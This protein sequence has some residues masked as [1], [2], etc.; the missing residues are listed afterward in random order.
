MKFISYENYIVLYWDLPENFVK[1]NRYIIFEGNKQIA[2]TEQC[3]IKIGGL[4][5]DSTHLFTV[6]MVGVSSADLGEI[7]ART[8]RI[9][10]R[11]DVTS[12]PYFAVGDGKTLNTAALQQAFDDCGVNDVIYI[13]PG[14]FLTGSLRLHSDT[15]LYL[16]KGA[17][18]HGTTCVSDYEPKIKSRFEGSE[19][20]SYAALLN[21]GMLE[22]NSSDTCSNIR[23]FGEGTVCGGGLTLAQNVVS[24]ETVLMKEYISS[25]GE[26]A[27]ECENFDTIPGRVRPR[28][29]NI[30]SANNIVISGITVQNGACWNVHMI[31]SD[32]IV[33]YGCTFRSEKVWNGD[34]W[35]PDSSTNCTLFG[36]DFYTGDDAVAVKSGKNP[37]GNIVNKPCEHIKVF[38]CVSHF[39][40]G[41]TIG[42]EISGGINDVRI[43]N[44]DMRNSLF[45]IEIK[46]TKKRGGYVKNVDVSHSTVCRILMH[47]VGYNDDG[48][49]APTPPAFENCRFSDMTVT[50]TMFGTDETEKHCEAIE[51]S[52]F[53]QE[54][55]F[56]KNILFKNIIIDS[57]EKSRKQSIF[58]KCC[59]GVTLQNV[60]T[61]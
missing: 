26:A 55:F 1:G 31:Y 5:P 25:L 53:E 22:R 39:G 13:P 52:G 54:G 36:C 44:C 14:D 15:E 12:A 46:G 37:E 61:K 7:S 8:T 6:Q 4:K 23:I 35:D 21:I 29:I 59:E 38:D 57:G 3:H 33:T 50:A 34:G 17:I 49:A 16:E 10:N 45:G 24:K 19:N 43:W 58:L 42:S 56:A 60:Y 20:M 30:S 41:I 11:I 32:N 40:H 51:V 47:S 18:L 2:E 27:K 28:L 48:E 9:K